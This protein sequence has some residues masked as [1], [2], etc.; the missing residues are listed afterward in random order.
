MAFGTLHPNNCYDC[1]YCDRG[2]W[3]SRNWADCDHCKHLLDRRLYRRTEHTQEKQGVHY[4]NADISLPD[5]YLHNHNISSFD[6][7]DCAGVHLPCGDACGNQIQAVREQ[8]VRHTRDLRVWRTNY[9]CE[10][11]KVLGNLTHKLCL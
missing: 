5:V 4:R 7:S 8:K 2:W 11:N 3:N 10:S 6:Y 1:C 9:Y